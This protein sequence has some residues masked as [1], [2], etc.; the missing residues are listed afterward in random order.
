LWSTWFGLVVPAATPAPIVE[1][2]NAEV[3]RIS[4]LPDVRQRLEAQGLS[5]TTSTPKA[6]R[7]LIRSDYERWGRVVDYS[8]SQAQ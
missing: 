6:S 3:I 1:R 5:V 8:R 2:L 4:K 7:R